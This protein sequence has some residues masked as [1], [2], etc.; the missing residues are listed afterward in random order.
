M[1]IFYVRGRR[2]KIPAEI[3][4]TELEQRL[5]DLEQVQEALKRAE[6]G[7]IAAQEAFKQVFRCNPIAL[8]ITTIDEGRFVEVNETFERLCGYPRSE[9]IGRTM[10]ETGI[11]N[12]P[13]ERAQLLKR[14]NES[15]SVGDHVANLRK[16]SGALI[17]ALHSAHAIEL[18]GRRCVLDCSRSVSDRL[19]WEGVSRRGEAIG[20]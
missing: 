8:S 6:R 18:D 5:V 9:L 12:D 15:G 4:S 10:A 16:R 1:S 7:H 19:Y 13:N 20:H 3:Y 2:E 17:E 11:W 14:M